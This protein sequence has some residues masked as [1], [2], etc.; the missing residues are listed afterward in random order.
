[1]ATYA[2][3]PATVGRARSLIDA[4]QY[5]L[6]S[7]E[8]AIDEPGPEAQAPYATGYSKPAEVQMLDLVTGTA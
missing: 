7:D 6:D 3:N 1:M 2:V 8:L 4:R 5:V